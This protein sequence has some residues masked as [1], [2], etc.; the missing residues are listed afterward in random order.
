[1]T[2]VSVVMATYNGAE[3]ISEQLQS[4]ATQTRLPDELVVSDDGSSDATIDIVR[5]FGQHAPFPVIV[6]QNQRRLGYGENF[7]T[8]ASLATGEY[9]AFCDQD[10][11]WHPDKVAVSLGGLIAIGA[12][13]FVHTAAVIDRS[14]RRAGYFRQGIKTPAVHAPLELAPWSVFYGCTMMFPRRLLGLVDLSRRGPHTFEHD[15]LLSHDLWIYFL[16]TSL[17]R[18]IAD[19][20]PLIEYRQHGR[21]A[22]PSISKTGFRAWVH[23]LG[24][25]AHPN[26]PRAAVAEHRAQLLEELS[27]T[28]SDPELA[29]AADRAAAYWRIISRYECAR[30]HMYLA[31]SLPSRARRCARLIGSGGYRPY[32]HGGLGGRLLLKDVLVGL[33]QL[34]HVNRRPAPHE[35]EYF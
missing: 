1:M 29:R 20:T 5:Q 28:V 11:V 19:T 14:G 9:I 18:V 13:L 24:I 35:V 16:A 21:N 26:L 2:T 4:L 8:A 34:R 3:F 6:R 30:L 27:R 7:L 10:D 17:G 32:D 15:G 25:A 31:P 23:S 33:L 12:E 22:T